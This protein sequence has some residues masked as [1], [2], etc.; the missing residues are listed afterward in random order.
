MN[1]AVNGANGQKRTLTTADLAASANAATASRAAAESESEGA[2]LPDVAHGSAARSTRQESLA[3]LFS[4][5]QSG[6][7]RARWNI[8]QQ[9]F[10]DDPKNAVSQGDELV[11]QVIK[12][13]A[14]TFS[15]QRA[16]V[17]GDDGSTEELRLALRSYRSFFERLL[18]I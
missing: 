18:S 4:E 14:E 10:V 1:I 15:A 2:V 11:A 12:S 13:L 8:V 3:P 9:G 16:A 7:F 5:E 17:E 6:E